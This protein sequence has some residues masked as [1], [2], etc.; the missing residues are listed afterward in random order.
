MTTGVLPQ[1]PSTSAG[2]APAGPGYVLQLGPPTATPVS[3]GELL[4]ALDA[5]EPSVLLTSGFD[6]F[7]T[8]VVRPAASGAA[9]V[10]S[11]P[12]EAGR[13]A[14]R[15]RRFCAESSWSSQRRVWVDRNGTVLP[16]VA[17]APRGGS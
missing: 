14:A 12:V 4:A 16:V 3:I 10:E 15:L 11:G 2:E 6:R 7:A 9:F 13:L 5:L 8:R 1:V 17:L